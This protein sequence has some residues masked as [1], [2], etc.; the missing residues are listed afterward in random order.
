MRRSVGHGGVHVPAAKFDIAEFEVALARQV[1]Q[2]FVSPHALGSEMHDSRCKSSEAFRQI[3]RSRHLTQIDPF[4][5]RRHIVRWL[6]QKYCPQLSA[7]RS[8]VAR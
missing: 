6:R 7:Q 3:S 1:L 4:K 5:L 8:N 2:Q